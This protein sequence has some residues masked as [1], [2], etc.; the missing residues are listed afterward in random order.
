MNIQ[1]A[2]FRSHTNSNNRHEQFVYEVEENKKLESW[3]AT[4]KFTPGDLVFFYFGMPHKS[5]IAIGFVSS[6]PY[7]E[8][9]PFNWTLKERVY[10]CDYEP[11][12]L[13]EN[14]LKLPTT[15]KVLEKWYATKPYRSNRVLKDEIASLLLDELFRLNPKVEKIEEL[16]AILR[17]LHED[18][19]SDPDKNKIDNLSK[20]DYINDSGYNNRFQNDENEQLQLEEILDVQ[21]IERARNDLLNLKS[22]DSVEVQIHGKRYKRDNKTIVQLKIL[23]GYECQI[24]HTTIKRKNNKKYIEAAHV[25]SKS[26]KGRE[27]PENILILC[28]NHHKEFDYGELE[29][30]SHNK[31][32]IHF[33][34]NGVE[35]KINL[36]I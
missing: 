21:N 36:S 10:F 2:I 9:G 6:E 1:F 17:V 11:V 35:H 13:L 7:I 23:R 5:I 25:L 27:S 33:I 3:T 30:L 16:H 15:N 20:E 8:N 19:Y 29:I 28:P 4:S 26:K 22:S 34:L 12:W 32:Q 24:C 18:N 14:P 31:E